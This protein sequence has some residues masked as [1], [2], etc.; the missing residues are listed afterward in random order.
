MVK[1]KNMFNKNSLAAKFIC[2]I[3]SLFILLSLELTS[4][5][6]F[7]ETLLDR[8][9][10]I[11]KQDPQLFWR[12][13]ANLK[14]KFEG[15]QI[16]T[17]GMGWRNKSLNL[18]KK[19]GVRR[20]ICLG[21][22]PTFGWGVNYEDTY[23]YHLQ[24]LLNRNPKNSF[25]VINAGEIGYSSYQGLLLL[26]NEIVRLDPDIITVSYVINDIDKY[27]FFRSNLLNDKQL[28]PINKNIVALMNFMHQSKFGRVLEKLAFNLSHPENRYL[29]NTESV[30]SPG[31][32]RV[33]ISDYRENLQE[34]IDFAFKKEIKLVFIKMPVNLPLPAQLPDS[35]EAESNAYLEHAKI[36]LAGHSYAA[37]KKD[38]FN[39]LKINPYLSDAYYYLGI[40]NEKRKKFQ[41]AKLY[42]KKARKME[43][44]R[45][46][47]E[48]KKYNT[49]METVADKFSI[50]LTD[51]VSA[52][53]RNNQGYL[54]VDP[55]HDPIHP[56]IA[57]HMIIAQ[58][59]YKTL[60]KY[61]LCD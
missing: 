40:C 38:L 32:N 44:F 13:K 14:T 22:S 54:F 29:D 7:P 46:G 15:H 49:M 58:E 61:S 45:C 6:I 31:E 60:I 56:N 28:L 19:Q 4:R 35:K 34:I 27:R 9:I 57:G 11:L 21:A 18:A 5:V 10:L 1:F 25:E 47:L 30:Y 41:I 59:I 53:G 51:V 23:A 48:G 39:A 50:P 17:D 16:N 52:F 36:N 33:P 12:Q 42:F 43:V 24:K 37:A 26:K 2:I 8:I 20:I 55:E 3:F